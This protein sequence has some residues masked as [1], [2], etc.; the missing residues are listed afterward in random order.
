MGNLA[1]VVDDAEVGWT[2]GRSPPLPLSLVSRVPFVLSLVCVEYYS[3]QFRK[4]CF[5]M[6]GVS[7]TSAAAGAST[8]SSFVAPPAHVITYTSTERFRSQLAEAQ[9]QRNALIVPKPNV[10]IL[11]EQVLAGH[12]WD[13]AVSRLRD[14]LVDAIGLGCKLEDLHTALPDF[15]PAADQHKVVMKAKEALLRPLADPEVYANLLAAYDAMVCDVIAP[16][17]A[18]SFGKDGRIVESLRYACLPT[19]R[20]QTPSDDLATIRPH[21]DGMY[22]LQ[23][24]SV[25][26]WL[27]LTPVSPS[28][29]LWIED[30]G[31]AGGDRSES[32]GADGYEHAEGAPTPLSLRA[33]TR[34][35]RFDG[36]GLIHFTVP[37]RSPYTR[38][39]LDFRVVP[40]H[41]FDPEERLS[42]LGYYSLAVRQGVDRDE[43]SGAALRDGS[44]WVKR[45]S[46][47]VSKLHGLP[48]VGQPTLD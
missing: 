46:G 35:T 6:I 8:C 39:S 31:D 15:S 11:P 47:R 34:P 38:V 16:A 41:L 32:R 26:Y 12:D 13:E 14:C 33:L 1:E 37:N 20:V 45:E 44:S 21:C 3:V 4:S 40:G 10:P 27:P 7:M 5:L 30:G 22:G 28:S 43:P 18:D 42:Q 23:A 19:L 9:R 24:G 48:H 2:E 29:A 17:L 36:R 25:N